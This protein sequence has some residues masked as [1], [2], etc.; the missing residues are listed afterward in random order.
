M[1]NDKQIE[2]EVLDSE[3]LISAILSSDCSQ[4][5]RSQACAVGRSRKG[6]TGVRIKSRFVLGN[7]NMITFPEVT[8]DEIK[9][10]IYDPE[11]DRVE[12]KIRRIFKDPNKVSQY[13]VEYIKNNPKEFLSVS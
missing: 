6:D 13:T 10:I 4:G 5:T 9:S 12:D 8:E 3:E 7:S 11:G 1:L 2:Y